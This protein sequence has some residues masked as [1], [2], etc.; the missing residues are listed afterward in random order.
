[1]ENLKTNILIIID[2]HPSSNAVIRYGRQLASRLEAQLFVL[3]HVNYSTG[4]IDSGILPG[5]IESGDVE[6]TKSF[7][8]AIK[9]EL[10]PE[11]TKLIV[12]L[13]IPSVEINRTIAERNISLAVIGHHSHSFFLES[14][15]ESLM[16]HLHIPLLVLPEKF[17][18]ELT[19]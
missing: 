12:T 14:A 18:D 13:G 5:E 6:R 19:E 10:L 4:A 8:E 9:N 3:S 17:L 11:S 15:E 16:H 1:M 7:L 2:D